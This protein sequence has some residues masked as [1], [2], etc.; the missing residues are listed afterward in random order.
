MQAGVQPARSERSERSQSGGKQRIAVGKRDTQEK[1]RGLAPGY[2][3]YP[4]F[5]SACSSMADNVAAPPSPT[6]C[7]SANFS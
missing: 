7:D 3:M 4:R 1:R 2:S 5:R 6:D